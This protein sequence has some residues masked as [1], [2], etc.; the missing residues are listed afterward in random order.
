MGNIDFSVTTEHNTVSFTSDFKEDGK[1][2]KV[3]TPSLHQALTD[4][5]ARIA[6]AYN[7]A[8]AL[9]REVAKLQPLFEA[10]AGAGVASVNPEAAERRTAPGPDSGPSVEE[11]VRRARGEFL[12]S[13]IDA[14]E[15]GP[16]LVAELNIDAGTSFVDESHPHA[17]RLREFFG[18]QLAEAKFPKD[19]GVR[20]LTA[21][22]VQRLLDQKDRELA[23][24]QEAQSKMNDLR[25]EANER[26]A[27]KEHENEKLRE[28]LEGM[29]DENLRRIRFSES[30]EA[31]LN[32]RRQNVADLSAAL[33]ARSAVVR[34]LQGN[35]LRLESDL[36]IFRQNFEDLAK[37]RDNLQ[38]RNEN[39]ERMIKE[40]RA[41]LD[42]HEAGAP[43]LKDLNQRYNDLYQ[44]M[45]DGA[46]QDTRLQDERDIARK[47]RDRA[48]RDLRDLQAVHE[49]L[50]DQFTDQT[51][52]LNSS[53]R[54][55]RESLREV[56][57]LR[58]KVEHFERNCE[59]PE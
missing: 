42:L 21:D 6:G 34:E 10:M 51:E 4:S 5:I 26:A 37:Q 17:E 20:N 13:G 18:E 33:E 12:S 3:G 52:R 57:A 55:L 14:P 16:K 24:A 23:T 8:G 58:G 53:Q 19:Y 54:S 48:I 28:A 7:I 38:E 31:D 47:E 44:Q 36:K 22:E 43:A 56:K 9:E 2:N 29:Q 41:K 1:P 35:V 27:L 46:M 50:R 32:I 45:H 49:D 39:Q 40:M 15:D 25:R 11:R 30:Q 59:A